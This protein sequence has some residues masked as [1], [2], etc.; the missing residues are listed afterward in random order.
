MPTRPSPLK[1][2]RHWYLIDRTVGNYTSLQHGV[3]TH[4]WAPSSGYWNSENGSSSTTNDLSPATY[5]IQYFNMFR[6]LGKYVLFKSIR[7]LLAI[8][9]KRINNI[10]TLCF[11]HVFESIYKYIYIFILIFVL[12]PTY[13]CLFTEYF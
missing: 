13:K 3:I 7:T 8:R 5:N 2:W 1:L 6:Y 11:R 12:V 10:P 4:S 9:K